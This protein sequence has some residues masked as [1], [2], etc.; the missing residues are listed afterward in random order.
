MLKTQW[1]AVKIIILN[2]CLLKLR[3]E[4]IHIWVCYNFLKNFLVF[5]T[6]F[7]QFELPS[8]IIS[9]LQYS[10]GDIHFLVLLL[11]SSGIPKLLGFI[12]LFW[13]LF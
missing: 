9:L 5:F 2:L 8:G 3:G 13:D 10:F 4:Q 1:Y 7:S 11:S 12:D 6:S